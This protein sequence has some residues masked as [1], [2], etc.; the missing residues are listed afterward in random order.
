MSSGAECFWACAGAARESQGQESVGG[1][2]GGPVLLGD[3]LDSRRGRLSCTHPEG[4]L[5]PRCALLRAPFVHPADLAHVPVHPNLF[6]ACQSPNTRHGEQLFYQFL[7]AS[8]T[9]MWLYQYGRFESGFLGPDA[10]WDVRPNPPSLPLSPDPSPRRK[11]PQLPARQRTTSSPSS[12]PPSE[13][14]SGSKPSPPSPPPTTTSTDPEEILPPT[15]R[16]KSLRTPRRPSTTLMR[17]NSS[18]ATC[19]RRNPS[20]GRRPL[21]AFQFHSAREIRRS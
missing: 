2:S 12:S 7:A 20:R 16:S 11:S 9:K 10:F 19:L 6:L 8:A 5:G 18:R 1:R 4:A 14:S 3:V 13:N 17:S 21:R 15:L